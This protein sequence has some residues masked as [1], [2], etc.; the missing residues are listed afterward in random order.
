MLISFLSLLLLAPSSF[1][2]RP[3]DKP[4]SVAAVR[5]F[6][7]VETD[8]IVLEGLG[9]EGLLVFTGWTDRKTALYARTRGPEADDWSEPVRISS[10][11]VRFDSLPFLWAGPDQAVHCVWQSKSRGKLFKVLYSRRDPGSKA[12]TPPVWVEGA[13]GL[14][15]RPVSISGDSR[16]NLFIFTHNSPLQHQYPE[17]Q[18]FMSHDG[19]R[20]WERSRPFASLQAREVSLFDPRLVVT[21]IG[22]LHLLALR[23]QQV[24]TVLLTSSLDAGRSWTTPVALNETA[25]SRISDPRLWASDSLVQATW[26]DQPDRIPQTKRLEA[27]FLTLSGEEGKI[28]RE[29]VQ[30]IPDIRTL[31]YSVWEDGEQV[32]LTWMERHKTGP[33]AVRQ[34]VTI[35]DGQ[36]S[37]GETSTVAE[38]REGFYFEELATSHR[39]DLVLMTEKKVITPPALQ[40]CSKRGNQ[41]WECEKIHIT[42]GSSDILAPMLI[43]EESEN[44]YRVIFHEVRFNISIMQT[45]LDTTIV[46]GTLTVKSGDGGASHGGGKQGDA[47]SSQVK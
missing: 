40:A 4:L 7:P 6:R 41:S 19:G 29:L 42:S 9:K 46:T 30:E 43:A 17:L 1:D 3:A 16:G 10:E 45:V 18:V 37:L 44:L 36:I 5:G 34:R 33:S 24:T 26:V 13:G 22:E 25:S 27:A 32:G 47:S 14:R 39:P 28:R 35:Q 12:W 2:Y 21:G 8:E 15:R 23:T 31:S 20:S 11:E 38:S